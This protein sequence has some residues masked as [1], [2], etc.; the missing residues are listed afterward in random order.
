MLLRNDN[1]EWVEET[2]IYDDLSQNPLY[3]GIR[4]YTP[5]AAAAGIS[6]EQA[7]AMAD[8]PETGGGFWNSLSRTLGTDS[9]QGFLGHIGEVAANDPN[10]KVAI[11]VGLA[12]AM[13]GIGATLGTSMMEAGL[14]T[15]AAEASAAVLAAGGT[16]AAATAAA[17]SAT[18]FAT[19]V[20]T[21]AATAGA[22]IAQGKPLD[23]AIGSA[24]T[25]LVGSQF[26]SPAIASE[27]R[28]VISNPAIASTVTNMGTNI[29]TGVLQGKSEDQI[30]KSTIATG[31][32]GAGSYA[33][34]Q[35]G[36]EV[37]S[38]I[39]DPTYA[40]I[41]SDAAAAGAKAAVTG[42]DIFRSALD[43][44][45]TSAAQPLLD[46]AGNYISEAASNLPSVDMSGIKEAL[47]PVSDVATKILSPL[48][49][50]IKD[51]YQAGADKA[52]EIF[53]PLEQPIKDVV[54]AGADKATEILQPLEQPIKNIAQAGSDAVT[55]VLE[56]VGTAITDV[57]SNLPSV[58][59]PKV[60]LPNV[61]LP[62][63]NLPK[64]NVANTTTTAGTEPTGGLPAT[65][66]APAFSWLDSTPQML[67]A[68][69]VQPKT[70]RMAELKQLYDSLTPEL[71]GTLATHGIDA[72]Q[73]TTSYAAGGTAKSAWQEFM[74]TVT[75]T[76]S[77]SPTALEAAPVVK[78]T[79]RLAPL[80]HLDGRAM[81]GQ[82]GSDLAQGGL[83]TKYVEAAPQG[84]KPEFITGVTGYYAQG[85]GTGQSDDIPAMLHD[86]DYVIDA[87]AVSALGDGSS[88]AGAEALA[89]FQAHFPHHDTGSSKGRPVPAKIADGEYVFPEAFVT[90]LG[91][92]DNKRGAKLLDEMRKELRMHKRAAPTSKIPPKAHS[93]LDYLQSA[94]G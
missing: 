35:V 78:R 6:L 92:G 43:A 68:A 16:T 60:E 79:P 94:K 41:F 89:K 15:S 27:V 13:P 42:K 29:A 49:Q 33:G 70:S 51:V 40:K 72:P 28:S 86:G 22:Q 57:V 85:G 69:A 67:K 39:E 56:P 58:N 76:F 88:K 93:P 12:L 11:A 47:Q 37:A 53:Q 7:R 18:A 5:E 34:A 26:I 52:T 32:A 61:N 4:G 59:L 62:K 31:L 83:P 20:G 1:G 91:E 14:V 24:V 19:A 87:D 9:S 36:K 10:V 30:V 82:V 54:Q 64:T 81:G 55:S 23:Q 80:L 3:G 66:A 38:S 74:D 17:A 71:Q 75:P 8:A 44:G 46:A 45:A 63:I 48:E 21:A 2:P 50:P 73:D 90:A 65:S 25:S 84:H 77:K